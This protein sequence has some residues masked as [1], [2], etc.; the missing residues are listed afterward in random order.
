MS[1]FLAEAL[2]R[3]QSDL[4]SAG[5]R[6]LLSF[7]LSLASDVYP[8]IRFPAIA[9]QKDSFLQLNLSVKTCR[10]ELFP[11]RALLLSTPTNPL[12]T[13]T[14]NRNMALER[15]DPD[16]LTVPT[17]HHQSEIVE[18]P[19]AVDSNGTLVEGGTPGDHMVQNQSQAT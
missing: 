16:S 5:N 1:Q 18:N 8:P 9:L 15:V 12:L 13:Q 6:N 4:E 10:S 14:G 11:R 7:P 3:M 17:S 2:P 19:T